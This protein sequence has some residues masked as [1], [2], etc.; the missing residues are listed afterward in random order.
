[1]TL[2][3]SNVTPHGWPLRRVCEVW[4]VAYVVTVLGIVFG[5]WPAVAFGS[6]WCGVLAGEIVV[7]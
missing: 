1:M 7:R 2:S 4:V 6:F 5:M 3:E